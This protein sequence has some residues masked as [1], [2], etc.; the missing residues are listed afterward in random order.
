MEGS[1]GWSDCRCTMSRERRDG[2]ITGMGDGEQR[3][4]GGVDPHHAR[5]QKPDRLL[6]LVK[7]WNERRKDADR[8]RYDDADENRQRDEFPCGFHHRVQFVGAQF[9]ADDDGHRGAHGEERAVEDVRE[10]HG[11]VAGGDDLYAAQRIA[12]DEERHA[13]RP[14][15]LVEQQRRAANAD[16]RE[17]L[18]RDEHGAVCAFDEAVFGVFHMRVDDD[19]GHFHDA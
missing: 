10:R 13:E 14:A 7:P 12:L 4:E 3:A 5:R 19:D 15:H 16:I 1:A 17:E 9:M 8:N 11:D 18:P 6:R 2:E